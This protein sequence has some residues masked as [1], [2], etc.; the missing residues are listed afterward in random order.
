MPCGL[1]PLGAGGPLETLGTTRALCADLPLEPLWALY[2]LRTSSPDGALRAL[3]A[4]ESL[5]AQEALVALR[6]L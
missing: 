5:V 6:S 3:G 2:T 4:L 1:G